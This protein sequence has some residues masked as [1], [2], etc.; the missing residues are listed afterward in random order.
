MDIRH[1]YFF[2]GVVFCIPY[3]LKI[4]L[5]YFKKVLLK[6]F[7]RLGFASTCICFYCRDIVGHSVLKLFVFHY[8]ILL[9]LFNKFIKYFTFIEKYRH[10]EF[11]TDITPDNILPYF[12]R[13]F[14]NLSTQEFTANLRNR[15]LPALLNTRHRCIPHG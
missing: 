13:P 2:G 11:I 15:M 4:I 1:G 9:Y 7:P 12:H 3:S 5:L 8:I 10:H 6:S 14:F